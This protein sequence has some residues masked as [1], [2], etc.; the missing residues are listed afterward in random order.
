ML[1]RLKGLGLKVAFDS[2]G[3]ALDAGLRA[4]P[5][6]I[7]PNTEELGEAVGRPLLD[8]AE[9][10]QA[11]Q[12]LLDQGIAHVVVSQG[13]KGVNWFSAAGLLQG[14][15]PQVTVASTVGAGDSL[16]AGMLHGLLAAEPAPQ[17][18]RRAT[19]IAAQAVSQI[20]FGINDR[21]QLAQLEAG[22]LIHNPDAEQEGAQ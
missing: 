3:A 9:Q 10:R 2:S 1:V 16:L 7:K 12:R 17:T 11:A 15:P 8:L 4:T 22:V 18:L 19:A 21:A 20:G 5:W 13:E 6:L 14:V